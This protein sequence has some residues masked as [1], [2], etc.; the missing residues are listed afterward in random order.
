MLGIAALHL[1]DDD[2]DDWSAHSGY[3]HERNGSFNVVGVD[4]IEEVVHL[5]DGG[6]LLQHERAVEVSLVH[7]AFSRPS[8]R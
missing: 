2:C 5:T 8:R 7:H 3:F 4:G 1:L 6:E